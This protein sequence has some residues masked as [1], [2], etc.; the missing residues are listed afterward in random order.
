ME[1]WFI[2]E[3]AAATAFLE[4]A[5]NL[6]LFATLLALSLETAVTTTWLN[7]LAFIPILVLVASYSFV[8]LTLS[9]KCYNRLGADL[10]ALASSGDGLRA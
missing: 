2:K 9:R 5:K 8:E 6:T 4:W 10:H 7:L 3:S 1:F